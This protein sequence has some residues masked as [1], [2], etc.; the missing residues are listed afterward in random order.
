M[1]RLGVRILICL[2]LGAVTSFVVAVGIKF[3]LRQNWIIHK[4]PTVTTL[5]DE[6]GFFYQKS[7]LNTFG[8]QWASGSNRLPTSFTANEFNSDQPLILSLRSRAWLSLP[9]SENQ[10]R[11]AHS[12]AYGIPFQCIRVESRMLGESSGSCM[13]V[14]VDHETSRHLTIPGAWLP[15]EPL[16]NGT[17]ATQFVIPLDVVPIYFAANTA[18]YATGWMLLL[19]VP[20][21]ARRWRRSRRGLCVK[22]GYD[23]TGV[24]DSCPECGAASLTPPSTHPS[25]V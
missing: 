13:A 1:A 15:N 14:S 11:W 19:A 7:I 25:R 10:H 12:T 24:A 22:C 2:A 3:A 9:T 17:R 20:R 6:R 8:R 21:G 5:L 4:Y 18:I 16:I 23:L